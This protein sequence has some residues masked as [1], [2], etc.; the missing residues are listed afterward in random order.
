MNI[1]TYQ[2]SQDKDTSA[3]NLAT[4]KPTGKFWDD[5]KACADLMGK[6]IIS[7]RLKGSICTQDSDNPLYPR[8]P[9]P[10]K[11]KRLHQ[12]KKRN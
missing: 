7:F 10:L 5:A 3:V 1:W 11:A 9:N 6:S 8:S 12:K 4:Y 2:E